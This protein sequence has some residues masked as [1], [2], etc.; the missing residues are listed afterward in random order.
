MDYQIIKRTGDIVEYSEEKIFNALKAAFNAV[1][2]K[3]D[4]QVIKRIHSVMD[5]VTQQIESLS[6]EP[7]H[8][9]TIQDIVEKSLMF[10]DEYDIA[11][12]YILYRERKNEARSHRRSP[13]YSIMRDYILMNKYASYL[14]E[15]KRRETFTEMID[16]V[17]QMHANKFPVINEEVQKAFEKVYSFDVLPSMRS[18]QFKG[19]P[20]LRHNER[21]YNCSAG[22]CNIEDFFGKFCYLLLCGCGVGLSVEKQYVNE[23]PKLADQLD[24]D[25]VEHFIIPDSIEGWGDAIQRL[26]DSYVEGTY[27]EYSYHLIRQKGLPVASG[28]KA[29]G[30]LPLKRAIDAIRAILEFSKGRQLKPIEV[31]DICMHIAN[32]V[33]SGG[34]R[35]SACIC[36]FSP[37]DEEMLSAKTGEW[38]KTH[39]HR[40][41]SNN[42]AKFLKDAISK[43]EFDKAFDKQK[44]WGE[45][46]FYFTAI[47]NQ[48][49]NPCCEISFDP[50]I[51]GTPAFQFCNLVEIN[52]KNI[53]S[54][55]AFKEAVWAATVIATA[56][57]GYTDFPYLGKPSEDLCKRDALLGVSITGIMDSPEILLNP[58]VLEEMA[59]YACD[60]NKE[61]AEKIGLNPAKRV[62][63]VKPAGTTSLVFG[64]ASGIHPRHARRY[65]RRVQANK[66]D[67][68]YKFFNKHN[69]VACTPSVWNINGTDDVITF[70]VESPKDAIVRSELSA[71][72]QLKNVI[73]V[74]KHWVL[75]GGKHNDSEVAH[76]VSNT[77][78]VKD[79]EWEE[80]REFIW[81]NKEY[82][83]GISFVSATSDKDFP[84]APHEEVVTEEDFV[85]WN[86]LIRETKNPDYTQLIEQE[87]TTVKQQAI[88]CAGGACELI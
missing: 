28:G 60:V 41:R 33:V 30:H 34:I 29:P 68:V 65:F 46:G 20:I 80:V 15:K 14:P 25:K 61:I 24:M 51:N 49:T 48:L 32:A 43:E 70:C 83:T 7:I 56:Q 53:T 16:S 52:G 64:S 75:P 47:E 21:M 9:E 44:E 73:L 76:N 6:K 38:F 45:P 31:Y 50:Y 37:D 79:D 4:E 81:E 72:E 22:T 86:H 78:T 10:S 13:D 8:I 55:E 11:K 85:H 58:E 17:K 23:L 77:I 71:L 36:L 88:A 27:V 19:G 39:P 84:Q 87:D 63:C 54:V 59:T 66:Q 82:F 67:N 2:S 3:E 74:Q 40:G 1:E 12:A 18:L 57:A 26:I 69:P 35:R 5:M 42:S 62:T